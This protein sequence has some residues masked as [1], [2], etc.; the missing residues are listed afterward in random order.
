MSPTKSYLSTLALTTFVGISSTAVAMPDHLT[1]CGG[2]PS[3][4]SPCYVQ[5][6]TVAPPPGS[7][8]GLTDTALFDFLVNGGVA[9]SNLTELNHTI[10][11]ANS[12]GYVWGHIGGVFVSYFPMFVFRD[13][14]FLCCIADGPFLGI[15]INDNGTVIGQGPSSLPFIS[16]LSGIDFGSPLPLFPELDAAST[17]LLDSLSE[18]PYNF[19]FS[20]T[21]LAID[22]ADRV[23]GFSADF[24]A[25]VIGTMPS[26]VPEPT[27]GALIAAA[28]GLMGLVHRRRAI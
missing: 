4:S 20:A 9:A 12:A 8:T 11:G 7:T 22:D 16:P 15:S 18:D 10:T 24:G 17:A 14:E 19:W 6:T 2:A 5:S 23:S 26:S 3:P 21:L 27:S 13:G 25:F 28:L 1:I